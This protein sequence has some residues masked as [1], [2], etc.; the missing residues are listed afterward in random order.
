ML[1]HEAFEIDC[2]MWLETAVVEGVEA[3]RGPRFASSDHAVKASIQGEGLV[4]GR[5]ALL[6]DD[7]KAELLIKRIYDE[8]ESVNRA[9]VVARAASAKSK[10]A[11]RRDDFGGEAIPV[12]AE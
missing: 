8:R 7:L 11:K 1:S 6:A 4:L 2:A 9:A 12:P 3:H 5:S 10:P